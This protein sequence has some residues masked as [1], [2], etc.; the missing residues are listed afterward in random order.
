LREALD[1][2]RANNYEKLR[3]ELELKIDIDEAELRRVDYYLNKYQDDF[4]LRAES[5]SLMMDEQLKA[6]LSL[7][8]TYKEH[9]DDLDAA[10]AK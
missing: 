6:Y 7:I 10:Y 3:Y 9:A 5:L 8:E 1:T 2:W 4:Y